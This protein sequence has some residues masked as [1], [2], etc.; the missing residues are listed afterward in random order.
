MLILPTPASCSTPSFSASTVSGRPHSTVNSVRRSAGKSLNISDIIL[1]SNDL[2]SAYN[3]YRL[4]KKTITNIKFK[5]NVPFN[6]KDFYGQY[7][8]GLILGCS[9]C[10]R[11][12]RSILVAFLVYLAFVSGVFLVNIVFNFVDMSQFV[13][14][15]ENL[16]S[17]PN[18]EQYLK[19]ITNLFFTTTVYYLAT[20][21]ENIDTFLRK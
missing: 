16:I 18:N 7:K 15:Y 19:K 21:P 5:A 20:L 4:S 10:F 9:G 6:Q 13:E 1:S 8:I 11:V 3:A 12:F 17:N 2:L 14:I